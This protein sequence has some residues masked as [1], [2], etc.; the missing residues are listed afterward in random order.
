[1]LP[2]NSVSNFRDVSIGSKMKKNL[3]FRCAKLSTLI[4]E[5]IDVLEKVEPS[6]TPASNTKEFLVPADEP[7]IKY[8]KLLSGWEKKGWKINSDAVKEASG[9]IA[10]AIPSPLRKKQKGWVIDQI[11]LN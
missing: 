9:K 7:C 4:S 3:L 6:F 8:R 2:I 10:Y 11:P 1:L 5:D